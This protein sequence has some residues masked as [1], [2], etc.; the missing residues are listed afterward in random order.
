MRRICAWC[1]CQL[2]GVVKTA[3]AT[4]HGL[5]KQCRAKHF[6][7]GGRRQPESPN[8]ADEALQEGPTPQPNPKTS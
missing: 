3:L 7:S 1:G 2:D 5:C 8:E 4:T 6:L